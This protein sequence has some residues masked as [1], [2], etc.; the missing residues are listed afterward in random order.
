M[1]NQEEKKESFYC[2]ECFEEEIEEYIE[3]YDGTI[4]CY[5]CDS[6]RLIKE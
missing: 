5:C 3:K 6:K 1:K 2:E 4:V